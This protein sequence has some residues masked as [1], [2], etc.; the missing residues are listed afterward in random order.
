MCRI[1]STS[2]DSVTGMLC[3]VLLDGV[4]LENTQ[5]VYSCSRKVAMGAVDLLGKRVTATLNERSRV[6]KIV[7]AKRGA[8]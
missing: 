1:T 6:M 2:C 3:G 7:E 4:A 5:D 8:K